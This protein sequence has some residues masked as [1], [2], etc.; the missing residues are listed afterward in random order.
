MTAFDYAVLAV[1]ALSVALGFFRGVVS[2]VLALAAWILALVLGKTFAHRLAPEFAGWVPE[3]A[4]QYL[5]AFAAIALVVLLAMAAIRWLARGLLHAVGLGL[6]DRILGAIFG[7]S[8]G[9][10]VVLIAVALAGLTALPRER[11]WRDAML[12]PPLETA[13]VALKPWLPQ[14]WASK[15][16]YR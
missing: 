13:V 5:I 6:I 7:L 10:L 3:R 2:E 11:W 4:L 12:S 9:V 1:L 8:R 15:I 14:A 16:R